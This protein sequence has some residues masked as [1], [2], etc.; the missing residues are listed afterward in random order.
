MTRLWTLL[1]LQLSL[2]AACFITNCPQ[3]GKRSAPALGGLRMETGAVPYLP[4]GAPPVRKLDPL[5]SGPDQQTE[6]RFLLALQPRYQRPPSE[7]DRGARGTCYIEGVCSYPD[8]CGFEECADATECR[9]LR[10]GYRIL[11]KYIF[12]K[13]EG[14]AGPPELDGAA[15]A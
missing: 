3:G 8:C 5:E 6:K 4:L 12:S 14:G 1:A 11:V 13:L 9:V 7:R 10:R 2:S 15:V